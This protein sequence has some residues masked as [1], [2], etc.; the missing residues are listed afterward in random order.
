MSEGAGME[1]VLFTQRDPKTRGEAHGELWRDEIRELAEIRTALTMQKGAF[2]SE[3]QMLEIAAR[4]IP[5][6]EA[7]HPELAAEM[8]GMLRRSKR[9]TLVEISTSLGST[10]ER[11]GA[12]TTSSNV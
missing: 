12:R 3:Q 8:M 6:L 1:P 11:M 9:V 7:E 10:S 2:E 4:H 5:F